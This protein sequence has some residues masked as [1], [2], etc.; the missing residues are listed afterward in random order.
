MVSRSWI[1]V[2]L[3]AGLLAMPAIASA[4]T[5]GVAA[6]VRPNAEGIFEGNTQ[7]LSPG[8]QLYANQTVRT[9][10]L[11]V[12]DLVFI[13]NTN[14]KVGPTSEVKLDKFVYDP[15]GSNGRVVMQATRGAFR[16]VTGRQASRVYS[17][18]TPYGTLGVRGTTVEVL[19]VPRMV[20]KAGPDNCVAKVRLVE[21]TGATYRTFSGQVAE[22]TQAD[23]CACIRPD[24][25]V[26]YMVCPDSFLPVA[27]GDDP[28]I[29]VPPPPPPPVPS[30]FQLR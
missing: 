2:P 1:A 7:T 6:S 5:V 8:S 15:V 14:L 17:I 10:N 30:P 12:A 3:L 28:G 18:E 22:L 21:G 24:G 16:F 25:S 19:I 26:S 9:G 11:G 4:Q 20:R 27:G 13:D 29:S 23:Q